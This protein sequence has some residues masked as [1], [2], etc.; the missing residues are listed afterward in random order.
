MAFAN[1]VQVVGNMAFL[2][3]E[4]ESRGGIGFVDL[5]NPA[6]P[7]VFDTYSP[8]GGKSYCLAVTPDGKH[9]FYFEAEASQVRIFRINWK[10]Y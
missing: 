4:Q 5:S 10:S 3:L 9:L 7:V 6:Q 2:P 8:F 1:R